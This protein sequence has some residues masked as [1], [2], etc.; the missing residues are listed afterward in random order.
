Y[1]KLDVLINNAAIMAVTPLTD[2]KSDLYFIEEQFKTNLIGTWRISQELFPLLEASGEGRVV[3]V[4]SGAGAFWDPDFGL[5]NNPGLQMQQFGNVPIGSYALTKLAIN[6]LTLKL[7]QDFKKANIL[8]NSVCP[9]LVST[10]P[11]SPGRSVEEGAK[12]IVWAALL[13]N[14]GPTG[15]FFRDGKQLPW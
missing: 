2:F 11:G 13:S 8:V 5:V 10:Y 12:S 15:L 9:G 1:G 6:G 3:N 4:T 7:S 14:N